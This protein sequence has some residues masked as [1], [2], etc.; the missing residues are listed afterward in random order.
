MNPF[1]AQYFQTQ[2][3]IPAEKVAVVFKRLGQALPSGQTVLDIGC[4]KG[5]S[6]LF[7]AELG[8]RVTAC[9]ISS[10]AVAFQKLQPRLV[11]ATEADI[12]TVWP[13][14]N[15]S[16]NLIFCAEVIEHLPIQT[17]FFNEAFRVLKKG[18]RLILK[19]PNG[20]D[21]KRLL[22][23][24]RG[25]KWYADLDPTHI[26]YY[27]PASLK[28]A[29]KVAHF[30]YITTKSGTAPLFHIGKFDIPAPPGL[31]QGLIGVGIKK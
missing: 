18:G 5:L 2:R 7:F 4:G 20:W 17:P 30:S 29:L 26:H 13:F 10:E 21:L 3:A 9:D 27:S 6:P 19:T 31:G 14:A 25:H 1:D 24:L 28:Q 12:N 23:P 16:F 11:D 8:N 22:D 15:E